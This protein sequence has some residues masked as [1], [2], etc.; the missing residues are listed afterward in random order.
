MIL[1]DFYQL[2]HYTPEHWTASKYSYPSG[3]EFDVRDPYTLMF[4]KAMVSIPLD[5]ESDLNILH[6]DGKTNLKWS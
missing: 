5:T 2:G 1:L 4:H 6:P 3:I